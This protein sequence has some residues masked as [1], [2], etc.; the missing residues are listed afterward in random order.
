MSQKA[1]AVKRAQQSEV[2]PHQ[3]GQEV[4]GSSA[5]TA[6]PVCRLPSS[7]AILGQNSQPTYCSFAYSALASKAGMSG[8]ASFQSARKS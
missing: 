6:C 2:R 3:L 8:S 5:W 7:C 4:F 1:S